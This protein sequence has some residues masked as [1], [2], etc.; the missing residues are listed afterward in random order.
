MCMTGRWHLQRMRR[1]QPRSAQHLTHATA[2]HG[3][4]LLEEARARP[5]AR[6]EVRCSMKPPFFV[7]EAAVVQSFLRV[8]AVL[9]VGCGQLGCEQGCRC[10]F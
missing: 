6:R 8:A 1:P 4:G 3:Q 10:V 7:V 5:P 9:A 2:R